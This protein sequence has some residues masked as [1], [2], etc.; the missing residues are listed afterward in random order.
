MG[1]SRGVAVAVREL[2]LWLFCLGLVSPGLT[3]A[4][5]AS[6]Q[7]VPSQGQPP[8]AGSTLEIEPKAGDVE[9][10]FLVSYY[11]QDGEHSPV[12]GGIGT[13]DLQVAGPLVLVRWK[14]NDKWSLN[15]AVGVDSVTSAS[16]DNIDDDVSSASR[17]DNRAYLGTDLVRTMENQ[18][19]TFSLGFSSEY[20]YKSASFGIGW[21]RDFN[22]KNTTLALSARHY[23]DTVELWDIDG[24]NQGE[25]DRDTTDFSISLTQVLGRRTVGSIELSHSMQDGF[26]ST[27]FHEVILLPDSVLPG[28]GVVAERLPDSRERSAIG[29]RL[30]HAFSNR[31][32]QR[33]YYRFYDDDFD[34]QAHTVELETHFRLPTER[35]MWIY[36]ILRFHSQDGSRFFGPPLSFRAGDEFF[37]A[38]RD[39]SE[40][41]SEKFGLGLKVGLKGTRA[42]IAG[43]RD[44]EIRATSYSRDDGLDAFNLSLGFGWRF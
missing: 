8:A 32:V 11:D 41:E 28:G 25:A 1:A 43:V 18:R 34:V 42:G 7:G 15:G 21:S 39:L 35:E 22:K 5:P 10:D 19:V 12:T 30:H 17:L 26:L 37:T 27:P 6:A 9:I 29:L 36:P 44:F 13:E 4:R 38:D 20:D 31:V 24:I 40:F 14:V 23:M 2:V 16:T 33:A 3:T